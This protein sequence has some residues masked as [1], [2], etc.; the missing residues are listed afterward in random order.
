[1]NGPFDS[2]PGV[3]RFGTRMITQSLGA[4]PPLPSTT[5]VTAA[6]A[7]TA[8][9]GP[10]AVA[11]QPD[12]PR[13]LNLVLSAAAAAWD[14]GDIVIVGTRQGATVTTTV[15][16]AT[17]AALGI[18]GATLELD[19]VLNTI[20]SI[21]KTGVGLAAITVQ[22]RL[23]NRFGLRFPPTAPVSAAFSTTGPAAGALQVKALQ[24]ASL[25]DAVTGDPTSWWVTIA[26]NTAVTEVLIAYG[27]GTNL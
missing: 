16:Q 2:N 25:N 18:A 21:S 6:I 20:T 10:I 14:G 24:P 7:A 23:A 11:V 8:A 5:N 13:C 1:M 19:A 9:A 27:T 12:V 4:G 22:A 3:G 26:S 15:T 17:L